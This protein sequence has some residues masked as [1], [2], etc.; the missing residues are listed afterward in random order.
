M[1]CVAT[2]FGPLDN[3]H[4]DLEVCLRDLAVALRARDLADVRGRACLLSEKLAEHFSDEEWLMRAA[5]WPQ[6][7]THAEAHAILLR[8]VRRFERQVA[9][10]ELSHEFA[11]WGLNHLPELL[12]YHCIASDFG[13]GK[14]ALGLASAPD[15]WHPVRRSGPQRRPVQVRRWVQLPRRGR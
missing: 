3:P 1:S 14:F 15:G 6:V 7:E 2:G 10:R 13:F 9:S 5:G 8:Q 12:R 4:R 11:S